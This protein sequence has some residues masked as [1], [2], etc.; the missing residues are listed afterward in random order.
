VQIRLVYC[1]EALYR[2]PGA[3]TFIHVE[4]LGRLLLRVLQKAQHQVRPP[5]ALQH[6]TGQRGGKHRRQAGVVSKHTDFQ[7]AQIAVIEA[8]AK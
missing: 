6:R 3:G 2:S 8:V 7:F 4:P 5:F 1:A